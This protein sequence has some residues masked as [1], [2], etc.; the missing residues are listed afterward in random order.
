MMETQLKQQW[1]KYFTPL[2]SAIQDAQQKG[3]ARILSAM[4]AD[5]PSQAGIEL[6]PDVAYALTRRFLA[7]HSSSK[8][9]GT[10]SSFI[11]RYRKDKNLAALVNEI[12]G[13][14]NEVSALQRPKDQ[15][16]D[17]LNTLFLRKKVDL[18]GGSIRVAVQGSNEK[19]SEL[20]L[21]QLSSGE[22]QALYILIHALR[23]GV[24]ALI[25]D[26]PELSMHIDWQRQL[27][28]S[29]L[30]LNPETQVIVA[31]HSPEVMATIPDSCIFEI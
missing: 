23:A 2:Q 13:I 28:D 4:L 15:L 10:K 25:I 18:S 31:T 7:S 30:S 20:K 14:E 16:E 17:L 9:P 24:N 21:S 26:E 22:K 6:Q 1:I 29:V 27:I 3:I 12:S 8:I 19:M 11:S 5:A